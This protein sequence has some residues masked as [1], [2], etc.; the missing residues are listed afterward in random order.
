LES[1]GFEVVGEAENGESAFRQVAALGP[2]MILLDVQLPDMDGFQVAR[3]VTAQDGAPAV[4]IVS[5]RDRGDY[6]PL[7]AA[8]GAIG[9]VTKSEL[10]GERLRDLL[11]A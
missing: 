7:V 5:S 3:R 8:S 6:G 10:S 11:D 9:F 2:E 1:E 4:I